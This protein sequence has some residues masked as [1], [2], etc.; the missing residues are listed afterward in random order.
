MPHL[1]IYTTAGPVFVTY[2][3]NGTLP[4]L[5]GAVTRATLTTNN[6][7]ESRQ[8]NAHQKKWSEPKQLVY[9]QARKRG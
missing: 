6:G 8:F 9:P 4:R 5:S 2:L 3:E 7:G 1:T